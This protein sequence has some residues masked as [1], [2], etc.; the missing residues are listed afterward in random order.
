M[1]STKLAALNAL[2][3]LA[4]PVRRARLL[5]AAK[6]GRAPIS[7]SFYHRVSDTHPNGWTISNDQFL[8]HID[9]CQQHFEMIGL[10]EVQRRVRTSQSHTAAISITFDDG[11]GD[12]VDFA[13]PLLIQ[14]GIPCTYFVTTANVRDQIPF[15]HDVNLGVPLP[16][17]TI[18]Q[19]REL[20]DAGIEIGCHTR[21][22]VDF[23]KIHDPEVIRDE[24]ARAKDDLEQMIGRR[25]RYFAF[26]FG[27]PAQLTQAAIEVIGE[28]GFDGFCSA[29]GAYNLV[30]RDWF[31]LRRFH[32][33]P[34]FARLQNW[35]SIDPR[36]IRQEP[37]IRYFLPPARSFIETR[38]TIGESTPSLASAH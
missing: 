4:R 18:G 2:T 13:M 6:Q 1:S 34:E 20:A 23:S 28:S 38:A 3:R 9:H 15:E 29:F 7:I 5:Q 27:M 31:H 22:H 30:D 17:N 35:L 37:T 12:N 36:K 24:V 14:R 16:V 8:R 21:N 19:I 33:D 25:V 11:Y 32:G 26:P 10:D